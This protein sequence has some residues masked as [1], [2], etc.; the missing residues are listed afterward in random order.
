MNPPTQDDIRERAIARLKAV[1]KESWSLLDAIDRVIQQYQ[2]VG[3]IGL[4][5]QISPLQC[6]Y[7][8]ACG[9]I[10]GLRLALGIQPNPNLKG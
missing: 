3:S 7:Y 8:E 4:I 1:E 5:Q 9:E 6:Q 2:E 10:K